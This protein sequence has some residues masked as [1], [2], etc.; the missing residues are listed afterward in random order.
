VPRSSVSL[1][2]LSSTILVTW[3]GG[4]SARA[5]EPAPDPGAVLFSQRCSTCHNL[6]GGP[7]VGPDLLGVIKR[8]PKEWVAKFV[9]GPGAMIDRGDPV[10]TELFA[11]FTP[12]RMPDQPL[13]DGELDS[14]WSYFSACTDRGGC[15]PIPLGPKWGTDGTDEEVALGRDLYRGQ[16]RLQNGGAPCFACHSV[17]DEG[18]LGGGTLGADL[19]FSYARLG[20]KEM[21]PLLADMGTPMMRAV[22]DEAPLEAAEQYALKAY[23]AHLARD[24]RSP[25]HESDFFALGLEGM[26]LMLGLFALRSARLRARGGDDPG[27]SRG[28]AR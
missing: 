20:E 7:K 13:T 23:F 14:V 4:S 8:R 24:G 27:A 19:T 3:I 9:R 28:G 5:G 17:R 16:R 15:Q 22:Y 25:R 18:L 21:T 12:I 10:A 11:K 2:L 1:S 26:A 6:G